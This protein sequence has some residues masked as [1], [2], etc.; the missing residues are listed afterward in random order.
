MKGS[1]KRWS[2]LQ[3]TR[4]QRMK[5]RTGWMGWVGDRG[6][7]GRE[8][9]E[10][11]CWYTRH[12]E[13]HSR[14]I[15]AFT[16]WHEHKRMLLPTATQTRAGIPEGS[17]SLLSLPLKHTTQVTFTQAEPLQSSIGFTSITSL[18][19]FR[20]SSVSRSKAPNARRWRI[21]RWVAV[22]VVKLQELPC[23]SGN[24]NFSHLSWKSEVN[25]SVD[26]LICY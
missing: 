6:A 17:T 1:K 4:R 22:E 18:W 9:S 8:N 13:T 12:W 10:S 3:G 19:H 7:R 26:N 2:S 15:N 25:G 23:Q 16:Q 5:K 21:S 24:N 11:L 20:S 14:H